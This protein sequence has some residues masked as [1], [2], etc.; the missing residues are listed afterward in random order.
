ME[1]GVSAAT[2]AQVT[3]MPVKRG[4]RCFQSRRT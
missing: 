2:L 4:Q 3:A 1:R